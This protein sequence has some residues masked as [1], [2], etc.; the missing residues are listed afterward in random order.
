MAERSGGQAEGLAGQL[1]GL[2]SYVNEVALREGLR[3]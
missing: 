3:P 1:R 2:Q